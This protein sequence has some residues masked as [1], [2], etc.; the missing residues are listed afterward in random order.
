MGLVAEEISRKILSLRN[1]FHR[2]LV[3]RMRELDFCTNPE[4][5]EAFKRWYLWDF[6]NV[7]TSKALSEEGLNNA[8]ENLKLIR[9]DYALRTLQ[10]KY[11]YN[12][13]RELRRCTK[14]QIAAIIAIGKHRLGLNDKGLKN[15]IESTLHK[16][17]YLWDITI[18]EAHSVIKRLEEWEAKELTRRK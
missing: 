17:V 12:S 4:I 6:H 1:K 5:V 8:I 7:E 15:Y 16:K 10:I 18:E 3:K 14:G 9:K 13:E 11:K 2:S